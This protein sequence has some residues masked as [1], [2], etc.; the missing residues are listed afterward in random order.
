MRPSRGVLRLECHEGARKKPNVVESVH[1]YDPAC[2][3]TSGFRD[4]VQRDFGAV[5]G[6]VCETENGLLDRYDFVMYFGAFEEFDFGVLDAYRG[7]TD[8]AFVHVRVPGWGMI[9]MDDVF[10]ARKMYMER[11]LDFPP[12]AG[13]PDRTVRDLAV[14]MQD[15]TFAFVEVYR[16]EREFEREKYR[17]DRAE[18]SDDRA[19]RSH[20]GPDEYDRF[21]T[22]D[23]G[24]RTIVVGALAAVTLIASLAMSAMR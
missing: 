13:A 17:F 10:A 8:I 3:D 9:V 22:Q 24:A 6:R 19:F 5:N 20:I 1:F 4:A 11:H 18:T 12:D 15:R 7:R 21:A 14:E 16:R 2:P 23:G